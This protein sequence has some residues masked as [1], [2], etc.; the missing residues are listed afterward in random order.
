[1]IFLLPVFT[2]LLIISVPLSKIPVGRI[3][4]FFITFTVLF[5]SSAFVT[6]TNDWDAYQYF[7]ENDVKKDFIFNFLVSLCKKYNLSFESFMIIYNF[8]ISF[9]FVYFISYFKKN[10]FIIGLLYYSLLYLFYINQIRY[11]LAYPLAIIALYQYFVKGKI[12]LAGVIF[13]IAL[14]AHS[15]VVLLLPI[16]IVKHIERIELKKLFKY[17]ALFNLFLA[18]VIIV[19]SAAIL[20]GFHTYLDSEFLA[21]F[22]GGV[23]YFA[24]FTLNLIIFRY[25]TSKYSHLIADQEQRVFNFILKMSVFPFCYLFIALFVQA[26]GHRLIVTGILFQIIAFFFLIDKLS[27]RKKMKSYIIFFCLFFINVF[28]FYFL[29][30]LINPDNSLEVIHDMFLSNPIYKYIL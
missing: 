29:P 18:A 2:F 5:I 27:P 13:L 23:F 28:Y 1:M 4:L 12:Y 17:S 24:I 30:Q 26:I 19:F 21:S 7:Y 6:K 9:F 25:W 15:G 20:G 16:V 11:F 10:T 22:S 3:F 8:L 14:L